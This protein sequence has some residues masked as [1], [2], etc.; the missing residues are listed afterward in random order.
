MFGR[1]R[2]GHGT[3]RKVEEVGGGTQEGV[4]HMV[5]AWGA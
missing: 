1:G 3:H 5:K 2:R 4:D